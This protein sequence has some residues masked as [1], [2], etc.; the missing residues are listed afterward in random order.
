EPCRTATWARSASPSWLT[1]WKTPAAPTRTCSATCAVRAR[2]LAAAGRWIRSWARNEVAGTM[3]SVRSS[4]D[5]EQEDDQ[6]MELTEKVTLDDR[7]LI[8]WYKLPAPGQAKVQETLGNMAG[9][10]LERV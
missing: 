10:V 6:L 5:R 1:R 9:Q 2:T 4:C 7:A 3:V 8:G